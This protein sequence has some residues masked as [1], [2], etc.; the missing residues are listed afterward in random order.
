MLLKE[1]D[2]APARALP[3]EINHSVS[4][5][6]VDSL[7]M[8]MDVFGRFRYGVLARRIGLWFHWS[9]AVWVTTWPVVG[10]PG[11]L[12]LR[13]ATT[14]CGHWSRLKLAQHAL[15][16]GKS[17]D[18]NTD[19]SALGIHDLDLYR[20]RSRSAILVIAEPQTLV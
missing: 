12:L 20:S 1:V 2:A 11:D 13:L 19:K 17:Q 10:S 5:K 14:G 9:L 6:V 4:N 15:T 16:T 18:M 7:R 8:Q 3:V